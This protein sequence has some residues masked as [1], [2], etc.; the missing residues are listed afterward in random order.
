ML[1]GIFLAFLLLNAAFNGWHGGH[2]FG[3]R[4]LVPA[5]PFLALPLAPV[6]ARWPRL[7]VALATLS[8]AL[9]LLGTAV[10]AQVP[11]KIAHPLTEFL[12][13]AAGGKSG[14]FDGTFFEGPMSI[15]PQGVY[16]IAPN[17]VF[18]AR[19]MESRWNSFNLGEFLFP[20]S[21]LSLA[22]L[23]LWLAAGSAASLR[24]ASRAALGGAPVR[25]PVTG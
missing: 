19:S 24:L 23:L 12:I 16:E 20:R 4:Y 25:I 2:S 10:T 13:P 5:V 18:P 8:A 3:P 1:A 7:S 22:P 15:N 14:E 17:R 21:L 9:M 11:A 6:L